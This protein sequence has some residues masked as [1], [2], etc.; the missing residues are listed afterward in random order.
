ML[1]VLLLAVATAMAPFM[2]ALVEQQSRI[3]SLQEGVAQRERDVDDLDQ[4]LERWQDPAFVVAQARQRFT[5]VMP[6][7]VGYVVLD[8]A[9]SV[10][11]VAD[12]SRAA[13]R[14]AARNDDASWFGALWTSVELAGQEPPKQAEPASGP[15]APTTPA[16]APATT[17]EP[18]P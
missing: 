4:Q 16:P 9:Q 8:E 10:Q 11:D 5:Y 17:Q 3:A 6:G 15:T 14:E 13:A 2:R 18:K 7:E 12:P 1:V